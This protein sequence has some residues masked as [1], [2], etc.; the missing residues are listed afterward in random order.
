MSYLIVYY[1]VAIALGS[2]DKISIMNF[3]YISKIWYTL[4]LFY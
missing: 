1:C 4:W 2:Y 3:Q